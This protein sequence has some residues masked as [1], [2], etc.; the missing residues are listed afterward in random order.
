M[1]FIELTTTGNKPIFI[2]INKIVAI[3][4]NE[5]DTTM[6]DCGIQDEFYT[7]KED[8]RMI[9]EKMTNCNYI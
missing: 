4:K 9:V 1:F 2:N 3:L 6:I 5:D 7:V 8:P